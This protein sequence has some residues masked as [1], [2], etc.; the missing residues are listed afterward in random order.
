MNRVHL[1]RARSAT[2][3]LAALVT[4]WAPMAAAQTGPTTPNAR[5]WV[6]TFTATGQ[7]NTVNGPRSGNGDRIDYDYRPDGSL[8]RVTSELGQITQ[9][10]SVNDRGQPLSVT[11][12]NGVVT[13]ISYDPLGRVTG[14]TE[15]AGS[16]APS[17]WSFAYNKV[18]DLTRITLPLGGWLAYEYDDARR[19][20]KAS[21]DRGEQVSYAYNDNSDPTE[22]K[23]RAVAG[24]T[25]LRQ[26]TLA[27][28]ELGRLRRLVGAGGQAHSFGY[29]RV[30]NRVRHT[31]ARSKVWETGFD[32]L[33]RVVT[34]TDPEGDVQTI[35]Y[36]P[37]DEV[38][39][40]TDARSLETVFTVDGFGW[41]A[42]EVSPDTGQT[43][44]RYNATGDLVWAKDA[45][46]AVFTASYDDARRI[47]SA[48]YAKGSLSEARTFEYDD[49]ANGNKGVGRLTKVTDASG[50]TAYA[51][52]GQG[53]IVQT[54]QAIAGRTYGVQ[55]RYDANG[56][57]VGL[58]LPSGR[59]VG[60]SRATDG[61]A[62]AV[63]VRTGPSAPTVTIA[64]AIAYAPFGDGL[65]ALNYGNGQELL[66]T[67]DG[68]GWLTGNRVSRFGAAVLD[69]SYARNANGQ[70]LTETDNV[71]GALRQAAYTYTN[72]GRLK[73]ADGAWGEETYDW[74]A[75]GNRK[76]KTTVRG[77]TTRIETAVISGTSNRLTK[78]RS[79]GADVRTF[80]HDAAGAV[81]GD[82]R[83]GG[84]DA[85]AYGYVY[86]PSGRLMEASKGGVVV[87]R[88]G[89]DWQG[90]RVR[91]VVTGTGGFARDYVY[92][93]EGRLLAEH[94]A[95]TGAVLREYVWLDDM[96]LAAL[97]G[98]T[99]WFIHTGQLDE[100]L[101]MT[102]ATGAKAWDSVHEPFGLSALFGPAATALDLRL[103]GQQLQL[104]T[105]GL[106][107]NWMRDYDPSLGRYLQPDPL[108]LAAG[109]NL[110]GYVEG[111]PGNLT[112][113]TGEFPWAL[114]SAAVATTW[115]A[116]QIAKAADE[117][118]DRGCLDFFN[119]AIVGAKAYIDA[120]GFGV[121]GLA[122]RAI[123]EG[124]EAA[125]KRAAR[126][127]PPR[128]PGQPRGCG[129][130]VAGTKVA[131][132]SGLVP[133][134]T[135]KVGD[136]V[137][138][139]D[140]ETGA[141]G[142]KPVT[143]LIRPEPRLLYAIKAQD[144]SGEIEHFEVTDDHPWRVTGRGWVETIDLRPAD[145]L[146]AASGPDLTVTSVT[147]TNRHAP[148]Y[149]LTVAGWHT[150]L[151]G[152]DRIVVHNAPCPLYGPIPEFRR[153]LAESGRAPKW[154]NQWLRQGRSPPGHEVDHL[155]PLSVGGTNAKSNLRLR[156]TADH[157]NRHKHYHPWRP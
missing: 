29:D 126:G 91:R 99:V 80:T 7:V 1:R 45:E 50:S 90:R 72:D 5:T 107:Q 138:A 103:P 81:T 35:A 125:A 127:S 155:L 118:T 62:T 37:Q 9:V 20:T 130:F 39:S 141:V 60:I 21:N 58:T 108:G 65:T 148:T 123:G 6:T 143:A 146:D 32:G 124:V 88:Y 153:S 129:C 147:L 98:S 18:G 70:V 142:P 49:V 101:V 128:P 13:S 57:L 93:V 114:F 102:D 59:E 63:G 79:G 157:R 52:D 51:Y 38:R 71:T 119:L 42:R 154:M 112:D 16:A 113:P 11:D 53:R 139:Y 66:R 3:C 67:Y 95:G 85:G 77:G 68:N 78:V 30:D 83:V 86:S 140:E 2:A 19:L 76:S 27:Y 43:D 84:A 134:E 149:N 23:V 8:L 135:L 56:A 55:Y 75:A 44:Y 96:P 15:D 152:D 28:D 10:T 40:F 131:T 89:Y 94:D 46:G 87:G 110:Y 26:Q 47:T 12:P 22:R 64:S 145:P 36:T 122:R 61:R 24:G 41:T 151:V 120:S 69:L 133:I 150:F 4:A 121:R 137:L 31:D 54:A 74:D 100:P 115:A 104:E 25:I 14:V 132:P 144:D 48:S 116:G 82:L 156:T 136:L 17:A 105:G 117:Q 92:D 97:D 106:H 109:Q 34:E 33:D 73:T 111:D